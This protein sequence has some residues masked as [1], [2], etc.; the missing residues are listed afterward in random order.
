MITCILQK[1]YN[2]A[3]AHTLIRAWAS[4]ARDGLNIAC[5]ASVERGRG[6][7]GRGKG[8]GIGKRG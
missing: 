2:N 4:R 1:L 7:E 3:D 6:L 8:R 5:V